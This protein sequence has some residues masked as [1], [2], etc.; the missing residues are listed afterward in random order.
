MIIGLNYTNAATLDQLNDQMCKVMKEISF[1]TTGNIDAENIR[2]R[3]ITSDLIVAGTITT[4]EIADGSVTT[5]KVDTAAITG[6][7]IANTTIT[8][9]KIVTGTITAD[10][11]SVSYLSAITADLGTI[12]AGSITGITIT[13]GTIRT[14]ASGPRL[15]MSSDSL[16]VYD[17]TGSR[18]SINA[19]S[20]TTTSGAS[21]DFQTAGTTVANLYTSGSDFKL[22]TTSMD[23]RINPGGT[24]YFYFPFTKTYN[25]STGTSISS[26]FAPF[27]H[28]QSW[29]TITGTPT[30]LSGYGITD[31]YTKTQSDTNFAPFSHTQAWS[32]I[33]GT[34]TTISGYNITDAATKG[35]ASDGPST[36]TTGGSHNHGLT[37]THEVYMRNPTTLATYWQ[38]YVSYAG[39]TVPTAT[40]THSQN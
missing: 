17:N 10:K 7:K 27:S 28:N 26:T 1:L 25:S 2:A 6:A 14:S 33:T 18:L 4:T 13:G 39:F 24:G 36:T 40:H 19:F 3:S 34:P 9:N 8:G 23:I 35:V 16:N 20:A 15:Q 12:T 11:L 5:A 32:T 38:T 21:I 29:S 37:S 22:E 31:A 30:T